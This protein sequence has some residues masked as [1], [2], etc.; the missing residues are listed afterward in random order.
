[1][2]QYSTKAPKNARKWLSATNS[3]FLSLLVKNG[4]MPIPYQSAMVVKQEDVEMELGD[5]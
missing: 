4:F 5:E 1:M 2:Y 3:N